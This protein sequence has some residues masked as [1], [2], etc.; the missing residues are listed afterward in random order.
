M[1]ITASTAI[2]SRIYQITAIDSP[3]A[4]FW[5]G[6]GQVAARLASGQLS[7]LLAQTFFRESAHYGRLPRP[8][9]GGGLRQTPVI[10]GNCFGAPPVFCPQPR[11]I[12]IRYLSVIPTPSTLP[13]PN[14]DPLASLEEQTWLRSRR[15]EFIT[16]VVSPCEY[17]WCSHACS[18][19]CDVSSLSCAVGA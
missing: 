18:A 14:Q 10:R 9:S 15:V 19:V 1:I 8:P 11:D 5:Y 6:G 3:F 7:L 2:D 17:G 16:C 13:S 12:R 4:C